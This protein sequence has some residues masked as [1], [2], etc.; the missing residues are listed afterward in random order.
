MKALPSLLAALGLVGVFFALVGFVML[1][2]SGG[3]VGQSDLGWIG[4][5]LVVGVV[6]LL[7]SAALNFDALR[8]RLSSGEARRA[9]RYGSSAVASTLISIVLLGL[10]GF[11]GTRYTHRFDWSEQRIHTLSEQ[12]L[13]VL[14]GLSEDVRVT[15]LVAKVEQ[16]PVRALL[17]RYANESERF[18]VDYA[19]PNERPGL[20]QQLG[21]TPEQLGGGLIHVEIGADSL[22]L[23]SLSEE[24]LTNAMVKLTRRGEKVVYFLEGHGEKAVEGEI[25]AEGSGYTRAAD[26]LRNENYSVRTLLLASLADVP[27]DADVVLVAGATRP[28]LDTELEALDRYLARGGAVFALVDPRVGTSFVDRLRGWGADLGDDLVID[29]ARALFGQP[30]APLAATYDTDHPITGGLRETT[31]FPLA[32]SAQAVPGSDFTEIVYTGESSWA[33]TDLE[34]L[35]A[36]G[37]VTLDGADLRGPVPLAVVGTPNVADGDDPETSPRLAVFGDADFASNQYID[38][39]RNRDLFVN[40]VNWLMGDVEAIAIRPNVSRASR[41][42]PSQEQFSTIRT[43]ALFALPELI[44]VLGVMTWWSRRNPTG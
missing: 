34:G 44:A 29:R 14:A 7:A 36:E 27:E 12:S 37:Q 24:S 17:D 10:L 2:F 22:N 42:Q 15:A 31:L 16:P 23:D 40:T 9:G 6:L 30:T 5:N 4:G 43:M 21:V 39:Y 19:D 3:V 13:N 26:A 41:F 25:G 38:A 35:E 20:V 28:L 11:L 1:L 8:E 32:R 18:V 33:E